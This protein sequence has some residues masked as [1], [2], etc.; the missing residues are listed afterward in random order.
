MLAVQ[1]GS[2][3][4]FRDAVNGHQSRFGHYPILFAMKVHRRLSA[5]GPTG[6]ALAAPPR[7]DGNDIV[8]DTGAEKR[9]ISLDAQR[10]PLQARVGPL[11]DFRF[12]NAN[13]QHYLISD[14]N[15]IVLVNS[16]SG[17]VFSP[18]ITGGL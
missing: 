15:P 13:P 4:R 14:T 8:A 16:S 12:E 5:T 2:I 11:K 7:I 6:C 9:T 17:S 1:R 18:D 10:R 3:I